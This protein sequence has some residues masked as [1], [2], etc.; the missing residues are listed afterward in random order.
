MDKYFFRKTFYK[1]NLTRFDDFKIEIPSSIT[2]EGNYLSD[3]K[4]PELRIELDNI[5]K[6]ICNKLINSKNIFFSDLIQWMKSIFP[7]TSLDT[8]YTDIKLFLIS[9]NRK[10]ILNFFPIER[11]SFI[12]ILLWKY[13]NL[14]NDTRIRYDIQGKNKFG[15]FCEIFKYVFKENIFPIAF[16]IIAEL[17]VVYLLKNYIKIWNANFLLLLLPLYIYLNLLISL[18]IHETVH[19][20]VYRSIMKNFSG[21]LVLRRFTFSII[22]GKLRK[23][24]SIKVRAS[25]AVFTVLL[26]IILYLLSKELWVRIPAVIF[27][28]HIINLLPIFGDGYEIVKEL[29]S[30]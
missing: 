12:G 11:A 24:L 18:V 8:L 30:H 25:G 4:I 22:R 3:D 19:L 21:Y 29:L 5:R 9:M 16:I 2:I 15:N 20:I 23:S 7:T 1:N 10:G 17:I 26:G 6:I 28:F 27:L 14:K 13:Q